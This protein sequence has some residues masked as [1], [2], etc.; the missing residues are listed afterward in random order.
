MTLP[1]GLLDALK[2]AGVYADDS[3]V[4]QLNTWFGPVQ[5]GGLAVVRVVEYGGAN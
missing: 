2:Y 4:R 5:E 3:Q 1:K